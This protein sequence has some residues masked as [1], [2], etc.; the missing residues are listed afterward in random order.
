MENKLARKMTFWHVWAL[1]TGA[2]VG[3]GIFLMVA[4]GAQAAGPSAALSY[5]IGGLLL[6]AV[7]MAIS[8]LA[9][10]MPSAGAMHTWS[11]RVLGPAWGV[12][13]GLTETAMNIIFLG[14]VSIAVGAISNYFFMFGSN[15]S[16]SAIIWAVLI[17]GIVVV[18]A[19][20]GGEITGRSQF[21]LVAVLAGI[22]LC[23]AIFGLFSGKIQAENYR[24]FAPFGVKGMWV[25]MG[26]GIYAYMGPLTL[27][28]AGDEVKDVRNLPKGMFWAFI[29]F[30]VL[31]TTAMLVMVGL[32][33]FTNYGA[34]ESP[35]T[36]AA[37][38]VFGKAAGLII[39][40]AA[41]L[42]AVTCL[43]G[44][45]FCASRLLYGMSNDGAVPKKFSLLNKYK[46]PWV[47]ILFSFGVAFIIIIIGNLRALE[48][49]YV[50]MA[51]IGSVAG[52]IC[53]LLSLITGI[54]YKKKFAE[55]WNNLPWRLPARKVLYPVAFLGV[56]IILYALFS[57]SPEA[58]VPSIIF[59]VV[60]LLFYKFYSA[61]N[62]KKLAEKEK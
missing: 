19:L 30:L 23:F 41:W 44:E 2:V 29:T 40:F 49:F 50:M 11:K 9:V 46:V 1:G 62:T 35:F 33:H 4:Q 20:L 60:I 26:M 15:E 22:M 28:T 36:A 8:E 51:I 43:I 59:I 7:C 53:M 12:T 31:Y 16:V 32:V 55:E 14:S 34:M 5:F 17:L 56:G 54:Y 38:L 13:A 42:A 6:M 3:D 24:P 25:A 21:I 52:T 47:G 57:S 39:N 18:I 10:G 48:S 37:T 45:V 27:L 61:P 58:L